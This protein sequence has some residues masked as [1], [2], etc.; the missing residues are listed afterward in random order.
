LLGG[1]DDEVWPRADTSGLRADAAASDDFFVPP[2]L[3]TL[4][5]FVLAC[6]GWR[7]YLFFDLDGFSVK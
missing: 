4:S 1:F 6:V 7:F 3:P 5:A 2:L